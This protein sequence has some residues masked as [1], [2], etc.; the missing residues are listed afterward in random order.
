[1]KPLHK[2]QFGEHLE[3][4]DFRTLLTEE[5]TELFA[6]S[7][8]IREKHYGHSVYV[9]GL[10]EI[11]SYC[12]RDCYYCGLRRSNREASR[13]RLN[14]NDILHQAE[15]GYRLG[16]RTFVLQ[17][18]EDPFFTDDILVPMIRSLREAYPDVAITLSLGERSAP[19]FEKL[20][21]AGAN[22][23]LLRHET[24]N[25]QHYNKLHPK[26]MTLQ[27]RMDCLYTLKELGFQTGAGMMIG[28]PGQTLDTLID[29]LCFL[30]DLKPQM[31]GI[32]PFLQSRNTP[33]SDQEDGSVEM[34]LK[35][36]AI[37]RCLLPTALIPATTALATKDER[38]RIKALQIACNVVMPNLSPGEVRAD[39]AI[40]NDKKSLN[41]ESVEGL[42]HLKSILEYNGL[43]LS[44]DR[45]D[46]KEVKDV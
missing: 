10:I 28:S 4:E 20:K 16:L 26:S 18:G 38:S 12:M 23:Y 25:A 46:Y 21:L 1:M 14:L 34:T 45:G 11:T 41:L 17:G 7:Q 36:L 6:L 44:L 22:R 32:G 3:R 19:S 30:Q 31:V 13:Y 33:F 39:Y 5:N 8:A 15:L 2:L 24:A 37:A 9:R 27:S 43:E 29:D 42:D 35:L 40:Y